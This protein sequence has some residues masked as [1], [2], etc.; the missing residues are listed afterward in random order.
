MMSQY[1]YCNSA[2]KQLKSS[3]NSLTVMNFMP[4]VPYIGITGAVTIHEVDL[5]LN[6]FANRAYTLHSPHIPMLGFL[7]SYKTLQ[8]QETANR[9]YPSFSAIPSLVQAASPRCLP[10]IHYNS[11]EM[12]TLDQQIKTIFTHREAERSEPIYAHCRAIQLNVV[13]PD[14]NQV[15]RSKEEFPNLRVALQLSHNAMEGKNRNEIIALVKQYGPSI[16]YVLIDPSGGRGLEFDLDSSLE[17]YQELRLRAPHVTIG[18]AG[19]FT[20]DTIRGRIVEILTRTGESTFCIDA[21]G[22]LRDKLSEEYGDDLLDMGKVQK[23]VRAA[24]AVFP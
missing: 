15:H 24:A 17:L 23:Y 21:E 2:D 12:E 3:Y 19:G 22:G 20:G 4:A 11:R 5:I 9:R 1:A 10:M 18:F 16:D 13:W 7:V 8:G 14:A 6:A